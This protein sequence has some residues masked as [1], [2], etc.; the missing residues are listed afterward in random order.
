[1]RVRL[2]AGLDRIPGTNGERFAAVFEHGSLSVEVYAPRGRD[3]QTPH[4][5][6]EVYVVASGSG[7]YTCGDGAWPFGPGD[8]LFAPAGAEHRFVD[9]TDDLIVWVLFYGSEGGERPHAKQ[10]AAT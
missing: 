3:G 1:M 6:D 8:L 4:T 5:R 7:T 9:F 2:Q 10:E